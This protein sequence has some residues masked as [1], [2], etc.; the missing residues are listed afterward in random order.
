M[1]A[2]AAPP[3]PPSLGA[4]PGASRSSHPRVRRL[5]PLVKVAIGVVVLVAVGL[6]VKAIVAPRSVPRCLFTCANPP[7]GVP[8]PAGSTL[9]SAK[10]GFSFDYPPGAT[11]A[12]TEGSG[13]ADLVYADDDGDFAGEILVAAGS[14]TTSATSLL[15]NGASTLSR[16]IV[17]LRTVGGVPGAEIGFVPGDGQSYTGQYTSF[18]GSTSPVDI[19]AIAVQHRGVW[20]YMVGIST[21]DNSDNQST[22]IAYP[23]FDDIVDRWRWH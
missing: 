23:L 11:K 2:T 9:N 18:D 10:Y 21:V 20:V 17:N 22:A 12:S 15:T 19:D 8:Q 3:L 13:V 16:Y 7:V 6:G 4:S 1:T 5:P 14:G